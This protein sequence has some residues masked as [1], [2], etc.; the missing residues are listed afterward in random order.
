ML[1][2]FS[3]LT[4]TVR[5]VISIVTFVGRRGSTQSVVITFGGRRGRYAVSSYY[6]YGSG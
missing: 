2:A 4:G 1:P 6:A 5:N 3:V